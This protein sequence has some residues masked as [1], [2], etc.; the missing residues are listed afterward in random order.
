MV[1]HEAIVI[2]KLK[3]RSYIGLKL[4]KASARHDHGTSNIDEKNTNFLSE[5]KE[6]LN[7]IFS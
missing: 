5:L 1:I 7:G 3:I 4:V 2:S 6:N